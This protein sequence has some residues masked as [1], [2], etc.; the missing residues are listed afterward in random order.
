MIGRET[1]PGGRFLERRKSQEIHNQISVPSDAPIGSPHS[2]MSMAV[3]PATEPAASHDDSRR[4]AKDQDK[5]WN[6]WGMTVKIMPDRWRVNVVLAVKVTNW[7]VAR[8]KRPNA[9]PKCFFRV[10]VPAPGP[11]HP[12][13]VGSCHEPA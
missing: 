1:E 11:P 5:W 7:A 4:G 12:P 2:A 9:V 6:G 10:T 13:P 8:T 3:K